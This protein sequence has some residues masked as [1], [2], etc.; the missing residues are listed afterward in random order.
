MTEWVKQN[1]ME[2]AGGGM[3]WR[4]VERVVFIDSTWIQT[5]K[6]MKVSLSIDIYTH[7]KHTLCVYVCY[8]KYIGR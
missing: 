4:H 8:T 7:I 5:R 3:D 2:T 6:I 1:G